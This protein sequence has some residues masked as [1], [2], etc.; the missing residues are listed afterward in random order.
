MKTTLKYTAFIL[1]VLACSLAHGHRKGHTKPAFVMVLGV[2]QDG[3]FPQ[4]GCVK[5]C[6]KAVKVDPQKQRYVASLAVLDPVTNQRW[7]IDSTP[8]FPQQLTLVQQAM[9]KP[10]RPVLDGVFLTH[11]HIGH[12]AGLVHLGREV[13]G[14]RAMPVFGMP[15]MQKFLESNGP[16]SQLVKLKNI[17]LKPLVSGQAVTLNKRLKITPILVPHRDEFSETVAFI[18][19]GHRRSVL[20]LPD[21]DKWQRYKTPIEKVIASVDRAYLDGTFYAADELPGR[22]MSEIPHPFIV[23]SMERFAPLP[24]RERA[25]VH[26]VHLNHSNPALRSDS[27]AAQTIRKNGYALAVQGARFSL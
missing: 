16:W 2:A 11:A 9:K 4:A 7:I 13:M 10:R 27:A 8:H 25:K 15:R 20:W 3:G 1:C 17:A 24:A 19:A 14:A 5:N 23:E 18:V 22:N 6:C 26:F 21:I 12:Y